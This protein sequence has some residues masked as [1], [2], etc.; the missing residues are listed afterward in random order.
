M[1]CGLRLPGPRPPFL[2]F[3]N[4]VLLGLKFSISSSTIILERYLTDSHKYG[5]MPGQI[6]WSY[7][8]VPVLKFQDSFRLTNVVILRRIFKSISSFGGWAVLFCC[9][10]SAKFLIL[11]DKNCLRLFVSRISQFAHANCSKVFSS[12]WVLVAF[13]MIELP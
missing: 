4:L 1:P 6:G 11:Q 9:F 13:T 5:I 3:F 10:L 8:E 12:F 2:G 7:P